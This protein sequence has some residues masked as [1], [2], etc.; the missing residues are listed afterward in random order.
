AKELFDVDEDLEIAR[1]RIEA[2]MVQPWYR[3]PPPAERPRPRPLPPVF[4]EATLGAAARRKVRELALAGVPRWQAER[5]VE[6]SLTLRRLLMAEG[7]LL[8]QRFGGG[9]AEVRGS[10]D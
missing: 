5:Q 1:D 2:Q 6:A 4:A 7:E 8:T 10:L 9:V 3:L